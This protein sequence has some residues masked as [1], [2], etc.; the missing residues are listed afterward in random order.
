[1]Q[2]I[3][4]VVWLQA[5]SISQSCFEPKPACTGAALHCHSDAVCSADMSAASTPSSHPGGRIRWVLKASPADYHT[6]ELYHNGL[7][8]RREVVVDDCTIISRVRKRGW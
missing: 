6:V 1:M 8:G 5:K 3:D 7:T 2:E 4:S